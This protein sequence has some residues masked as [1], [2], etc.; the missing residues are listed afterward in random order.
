MYT[1]ATPVFADVQPDTL[2]IDPARIEEAITERTRAIIPVH[3]Y[4]YPCDM[5]RIMDIAGKYNLKVI[6]DCAHAIE[7]EYRGKK[8]GSY[9]DTACYSFYATKN[10]AV[11]NG[12]M[13]VTDNDEI[14]RVIQSTRDHGM[15]TGA[16]TRYNTGEFQEYPMIYKGYKYI[17]WDIPASLGLQQ[18]RKIEQRYQKRVE[19]A[20]QY[21][22]LL[23][24]LSDFVDVIPPGEHIRH[25]Y[26]MFVV[27]LKGVDRNKVAAEMEN[28]G[29]GIGVHFRP[30]H[31]EPFHRQ[32]YG[33][34]DGEFPV[35][36]DAGARVLSLPFW[37]E[38][39]GEEVLRV[40]E[41][42]GKAIEKNRTA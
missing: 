25:A 21:Y 33:H 19:I 4:G 18:L 17:M 22:E 11:G 5:D 34:S 29:I 41:T 26:H 32:E 16:W 7:T 39:T 12:G 35:A 24:P 23:R 9:G 15:A 13:L 31:L 2:N 36:E 10:L 14:T 1:G 27:K 8:V 40:V 20:R 42:L 37:P 3:L 6:S 28:A 30:V 38:I